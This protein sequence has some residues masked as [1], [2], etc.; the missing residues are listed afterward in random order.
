[1]HRRFDRLQLSGVSDEQHL[2][3]SLCGERGDAV[4]QKGAGKGCFVNDHELS[5]PEG[6]A[7]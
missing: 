2:C 5:G 6:L 4:E 3:S 7:M 1:M